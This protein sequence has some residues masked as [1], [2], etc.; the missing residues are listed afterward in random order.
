MNTIHRIHHLISILAAGACALL[1]SVAAV[2]PAV[3]RTKSPRRFRRCVAGPAAIALLT[4]GLLTVTP[5]FSPP[6]SAQGSSRSCTTPVTSA[7][8]APRPALRP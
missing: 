7:R 3:A 4:L 2:P 8:P 5:Q 1:V 6:A